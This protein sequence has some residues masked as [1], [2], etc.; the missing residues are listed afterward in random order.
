VYI[1]EKDKPQPFRFYHSNPKYLTETAAESVKANPTAVRVASFVP[2][3][4][5]TLAVG[6]Y[7]GAIDLYDVAGDVLSATFERHMHAPISSLGF[8]GDAKFMLTADSCGRVLFWR[9]G[10]IGDVLGAFNGHRLPTTAAM[11][12]PRHCTAFASASIDGTVRHWKVDPTHV[13]RVGSAHRGAVVAIAAAN[14]H[15]YVV[16]VGREG[17]AKCFAGPDSTAGSE[18]Y[19]LWFTME[20]EGSAVLTCCGFSPRD[21]A[22]FIGDSA[23]T[24]HGWACRPGHGGADGLRMGTWSV[25]GRP[26]RSPVVSILSTWG[27]E[28]PARLVFLRDENNP[29]ADLDRVVGLAVSQDARLLA[30]RPFL[31]SSQSAVA[32]AEGIPTE[33][34]ISDELETVVGGECIAAALINIQLSEAQEETLI[35]ISSICDTTAVRCKTIAL[36]GGETTELQCIKFREE[37]EDDDLASP[38][39]RMTAFHAATVSHDSATAL[40]WAFV[41]GSILVQHLTLSGFEN[42]VQLKL[43]NDYVPSAPTWASTVHVASDGQETLVVCGCQDHTV[44]VFA[45]QGP[46]DPLVRRALFHATAPLRA[47]TSFNGR[48]IVAGDALGNTYQ[49][50]LHFDGRAEDAA[51]DIVSEATGSAKSRTTSTFRTPIDADETSTRTASGSTATI[52]TEEESG[53]DAADAGRFGLVGMSPPLHLRGAQ[54]REWYQQQ[55]AQLLNALRQ[56]KKTPEAAEALRRHAECTLRTVERF[57]L[58]TDSRARR[59]TYF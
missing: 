47:V 46:I 5:I 29:A 54:R 30:F 55:R 17:S 43:A 57:I 58:A 18:Q 38:R 2:S 22:I 44:R 26:E 42:T 25:G 14:E 33:E 50:R 20:H 49:L 35:A 39:G 9:A 48:F 45:Q 28:L 59:E 16:S 13:D 36:Y 53:S 31:T 23:G 7:S 12:R 1:F 41:S 19:V 10:V 27:M 56:R 37:D 34:T 3:M 11:F 4:V 6:Y 51:S 24:V 52:G 8:S 32:A 40:A 21:K 15:P